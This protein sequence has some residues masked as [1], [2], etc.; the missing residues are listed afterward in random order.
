MQTNNK[1]DA[2]YQIYSSTVADEVADLA[3]KKHIE[4]FLKRRSVEPSSG[5]GS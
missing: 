3:D 4:F 2:P 5:G 1:M